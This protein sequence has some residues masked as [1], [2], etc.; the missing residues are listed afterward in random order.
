MTGIYMSDIQAIKDK[1][2]E[3][4]LPDVAAQGWS[5][6]NVAEAASKAGF[7][8]TMP[9]A[10]FPEGLNDVVAHF[11]DIVDR[12]M[13]ENL[14]A[15]NPDN[16]RVRER[17]ETALLNRFKVLEGEHMAK[18]AKAALAYWAVPVRVLQGQRVLWRSSDRIWSWAG[19]QAQDYNRY[20]KRGLLSSILMGTTL[21]WLDDKSD[22]HQVT[23]LF[24]KRRIE[25]VMEIGKAI[26]TIR[27]VM[28]DIAK[29]FGRTP[30]TSRK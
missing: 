26:G 2:V 1:I 6:E 23:K 17:V 10:V 28:P 16:L 13:V 21:V 14:E 27:P 24:L 8:D 9:K 19:D 30:W 5:W 12:R 7:Q 3:T 20:T 15:I 11:S 22:D 25:N 29:G 4:M 18:A